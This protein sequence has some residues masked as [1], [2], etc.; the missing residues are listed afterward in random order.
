MAAIAASPIALWI[1]L[2]MLAGWVV[3][4]GYAWLTRYRMDWD[5][6]LRRWSKEDREPPNGDP[7]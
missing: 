3:F 4:L 2:A 1:F 5:K 6:L 7:G